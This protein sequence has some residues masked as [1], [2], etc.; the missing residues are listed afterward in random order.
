MVPVEDAALIISAVGVVR[1]GDVPNDVRE[2]PVTPDASVAPERLAAGNEPEVTV[3][4]VVIDDDP[5]IG[6]PVSAVKI[7]EP[8]T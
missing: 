2:D 1:V 4:T 6:D 5:A 7:A 3:P 8:P